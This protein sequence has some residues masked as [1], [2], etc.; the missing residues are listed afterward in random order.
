MNNG[1]TATRH[2]AENTYNQN[3]IDDYVSIPQKDAFGRVLL[4]QYQYPASTFSARAC[5]D[6]NRD[7]NGDGI[8][9]E[10]EFKWYLPASNQLLGFCAGSLPGLVGG[11]AI[12]EY[13]ALPYSYCYF[14]TN[15]AG[16]MTNRDRT[17]G[18][19]RCVR[20]VPLPSVAPY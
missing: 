20:N 7:Q 6:R 19:D 16:G 10:E 11:D 8:I 14:K 17:S 3:W 15:N 2:L 13:V 5:Y 1:R 12:T 18:S 4:Y 9:D